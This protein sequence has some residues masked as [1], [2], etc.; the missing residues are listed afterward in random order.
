M[1]GVTSD[2]CPVRLW[3]TSRYSN[4]SS[5]TLLRLGFGGVGG[6]SGAATV[7]WKVAVDMLRRACSHGN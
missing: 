4:A 2:D 6:L 7:D 3:E 5:M 1:G